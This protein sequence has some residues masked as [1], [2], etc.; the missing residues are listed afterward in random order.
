MTLRSLSYYLKRPVLL[1][2]RIG[3]YFYELR[4]PDEPWLSPQC[5]RYIES[6]LNDQME[7]FEW[8][9]GRSTCWFAKKV[10]RVVSI[11]YNESWY[12]KLSQQLK[13][14]NVTNVDLRY[15]PLEH[16]LQEGTP[17]HYPQTP[18]YVDAIH[19]F[20]KESFD[21]ILIDGHYRLTCAD[22]CL[23]YLKPNGFL[24]IDNSNR[25]EISEWQVPQSWPMV[26]QSENVVT[27]TTV[28]KKSS[29]NKTH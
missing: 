29:Q 3:Y 16:S 25:V 27:Q 26:H 1:V 11:E 13:D 12:N 24:V 15:I 9:S 17:R 2:K 20:A 18:K 14:D 19:S 8:G 22:Q 10:K 23:D 6:I 5:V 21:M 7:V 28:W 4:H